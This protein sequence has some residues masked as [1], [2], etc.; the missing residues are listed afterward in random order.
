MASD[1]NNSLHNA[2]LSFT[3]HVHHIG[4][5]AKSKNS[6]FEDLYEVF[7]CRQ[8]AGKYV[9]EEVSV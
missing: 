9:K 7:N 6:D 2:K 1:S 3:D 5:A 8:N 4:R